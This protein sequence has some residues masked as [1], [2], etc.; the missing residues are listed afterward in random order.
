MYD[1]DIPE[2]FVNREDVTNLIDYH[3]HLS[4]LELE[5]IL[6]AEAIDFNSDALDEILYVELKDVLA[7]ESIWNDKRKLYEIVWRLK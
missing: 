7:G 4:Q 3:G 1:F 6:R 5:T 2:K